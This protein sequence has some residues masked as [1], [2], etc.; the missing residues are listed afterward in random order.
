MWAG[1]STMYGIGL[2]E[3]EVMDFI[4]YL[5]KNS[6]K[7]ER[8]KFLD[9]IKNDYDAKDVDDLQKKKKSDMHL[10]SYGA[11]LREV[12]FIFSK[13]LSSMDLSFGIYPH[14]ITERYGGGVVA[15]IGKNVCTVSVGDDAPQ[16][17]KIDPKKILK[18]LTDIFTAKR[19]APTAKTKGR[20]FPTEKTHIGYYTFPLDC[21]CCT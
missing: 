8:E 16:T 18:N 15:V 1:A 12:D 3:K 7:R 14:D 2:K 13:T 19:C 21:S 5:L 4:K 17:E 10:F 9:Y 20:D 11:L 6:G